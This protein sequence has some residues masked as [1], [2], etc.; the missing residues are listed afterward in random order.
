VWLPGRVHHDGALMSR[1]TDEPGVTNFFIPPRA[2][3]PLFTASS[4]SVPV[5]AAMSGITSVWALRRRAPTKSPA[6][7]AAPAA[8]PV[9]RKSRL[10]IPVL[11]SAS[12]RR[13]FGDT[14]QGY[15]SPHSIH[16]NA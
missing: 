2:A 12:L 3:R 15:M 1:P 8:A 6:K 7:T 9:F 4:R 10:F 13:S 5:T 14:Y 11:M 16:L